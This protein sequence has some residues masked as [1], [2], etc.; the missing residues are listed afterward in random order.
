MTVISQCKSYDYH[1][2][3][4]FVHFSRGIENTKH[5]DLDDRLQL[6]PND[7]A[8]LRNGILRLAT[9]AGIQTSREKIVFIDFSIQNLKIFLNSHWMNQFQ[10]YKI[11]LICD[12]HMLALGTFWF[13]H[14]LCTK[15]ISAI[16]F[17]SDKLEDVNQKIKDVLEGRALPPSRGIVRLSFTEFIILQLTSLSIKVKEIAYQCNYSVKTVYT[18]KNRIENKM[19]IRLPKA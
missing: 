19:K 11:V 12:R 16:I 5:L 15:M 17:A 9:Y 1:R 4:S 3:Y 10:D 2:D 7:N 8:M 6:W 14:P 13:Y 18:Y